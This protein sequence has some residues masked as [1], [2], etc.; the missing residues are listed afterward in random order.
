MLESRSRMLLGDS[1]SVAKCGIENFFVEY[2][3]NVWVA[4]IVKQPVYCGLYIKNLLNEKFD[5]PR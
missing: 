5:H 2:V 4:F 1:S 3:F